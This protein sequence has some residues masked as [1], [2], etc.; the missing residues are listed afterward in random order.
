MGELLYLLNVKGR[1]NLASFVLVE[2]LNLVSD[3]CLVK[4][5]RSVAQVALE[6]FVYSYYGYL[7]SR[8]AS[9]HQFV[10]QI[11]YDLSADLSNWSGLWC[12]LYTN[13]L[14]ILVVTQTHFLDCLLRH[15]LG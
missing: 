7:V 12:F 3:D 4:D 8:L 13:Y 10:L 14:Y 1:K 5:S 2:N 11:N 6:S 15:K 9:S